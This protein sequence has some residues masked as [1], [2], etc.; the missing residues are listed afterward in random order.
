M[1]VA[2]IPMRERPTPMM[3]IVFST[4]SSGGDGV[5][6]WNLEQISW[7]IRGPDSSSSSINVNKVLTTRIAKLVRWLHLHFTTLLFIFQSV[8]HPS[9][10]HSV[11]Q[12]WI[13]DLMWHKI[14][15]ALSLCKLNTDKMIVLHI[16]EKLVR[17]MWHTGNSYSC[18]ECIRSR[19]KFQEAHCGGRFVEFCVKKV[20]NCVTRKAVANKH[21]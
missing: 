2:T 4:V 10:V 18:T 14:S 17:L 6:S 3:V 15:C 20:H 5:Q 21:H 13:R 7:K 9:A 12:Q 1:S 19:S 11:I 16:Q 8:S